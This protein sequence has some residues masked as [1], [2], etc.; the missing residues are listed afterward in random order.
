[1]LADKREEGAVEA[2]NTASFARVT[3]IQINSLLYFGRAMECLVEVLAQQ[4]QDPIKK[5]GFVFLPRTTTYP[6]GAMQSGRKRKG[7]GKYERSSGCLQPSTPPHLLDPTEHIHRTVE[8]WP[9]TII[10]NRPAGPLRYQRY[11]L[12][13]PE[14]RSKARSPKNLQPAKRA[15]CSAE[16]QGPSAGCCCPVA[17]N[18]VRRLIDEYEKDTPASPKQTSGER[19]PGD[20][21]ICPT[22]EKAEESICAYHRSPWQGGGHTPELS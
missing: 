2:H 1:M 22:D 8:L 4:E 19:E 6:A 11:R 3:T 10:A 12:D 9:I 20:K 15:G 13:P 18:G 17:R 7:A 16:M 5:G 21:T 14:T